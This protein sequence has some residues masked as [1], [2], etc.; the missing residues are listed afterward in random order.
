MVHHRLLKQ[1]AAPPPPTKEKVPGRSLGYRGYLCRKRDD[2]SYR[3]FSHK[4]KHRCMY[5]HHDVFGH[6]TS[7]QTDNNK[8]F[9]TCIK[10]ITTVVTQRLENDI[11]YNSKC[12][13]QLNHIVHHLYIVR[14]KWS[15]SNHLTVQ[16]YNLAISLYI[17]RCSA[18]LLHTKP[19]GYQPGL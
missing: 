1:L 6:Q 4:L 9:L 11:F 12:T 5:S 8:K 14:I 16:R 13:F 7:H 18:L 3:C 10:Q 19:C 17:L 15:A 2:W